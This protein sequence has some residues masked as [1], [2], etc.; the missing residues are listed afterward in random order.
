MAVT[1]RCFVE[2]KEQFVSQERGNRVVHYYLKDSDGESIL[3]VVGTERSVRH[4]FY[5]V[6]DE[7]LEI[8]GKEGSVPAGFKW[9]SR[10]EVVDWLTSTLS[11]QH[12]QGDRSG[13][14]SHSSGHAYD[15]T[16]GSVNEI[17]GLPA[18]IANGKASLAQGFLTRNSKL[19]K[20]DIVWSGVA[21]T[22]GKQL[23]HYHAFCRNGIKIIVQSFVFVMGKGENHYVAYLED[24]YE[25]RRGQK[26]VKA[27]WFHH[28]QE[29]K[30]VIPIRNPHPREV[31]I[32]PY[33]QVISAECIDGPAAVLSREHYEKCMPCFS[34]TSSDRIHMC[35]RQFRSNK[36]KP[37]DLSKLRGY[38]DQPILSCL[39]FD[40]MLNP[41]GNSLAGGDEEL[42]AGENVKLRAKRRDRGTPQSLMGRQGVRKLVRSQQMMVYKN[43]QG[44]NN[45]RT[46]RKLFSQK[47]VESQPWYNVTYKID[48][49]IEVLCQDSGIRGCWFRCTVVQVSRKEMK[50]QYD[51][52]QDEDGSGNLE[53]WIPTFK[54][55]MPDKLGMRHPGRSTIRPA[56][57]TSNDQELVIGVGT[58]IDAWWSD[59]WW[60]GV[61]TGTDNYVDDNVQ[62]YFPGERLLM[63]VSKKDLRISRDWSGDKWIGIKPKL[64]ITSTIF[65]INGVNTKH[66]TS[67]AKDGDS[68]GAANSCDEVP[69]SDETINEP[70]FA[71]EKVEGVAEDGDNNDDDGENDNNNLLSEKDTQ[72]DNNVIELNSIGNENNDDDSNK[73]S[74]DNVDNKDR[75]KNNDNKETEAFGASV[76]DGKAGEPV[77][78]AV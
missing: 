9:R 20:S 40:S 54:L 72:A 41:K 45:S 67:P 28:N 43:S 22:C 1:D 39:Q 24:M 78:M 25:D 48:D 5:V 15:T 49:K 68:V 31:F 8:C 70:D 62:A 53:E 63:K 34:P 65:D 35:F 52:I 19:S 55:A 46:D 3:A 23:K 14:P 64:D 60:E 71:E 17:T 36:V 30:G 33:S 44:V 66:S 73:D 2:W 29:V 42:S 11:K 6:A 51:D 21:W 10:R 18:P 56:P 47:E 37:F 58:A 50:A 27:R 7:F 57:P 38:Y 77:E 32:T 16:N 74:D 59:G 76:A 13:S 26:K 4:M 69:A 61:V 75:E 12:L